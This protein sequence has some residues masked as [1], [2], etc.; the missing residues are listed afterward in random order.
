MVDGTSPHVLEPKFPGLIDEILDFAKYL[1]IE[2]L[3]EYASEIKKL[4]KK[5]VDFIKVD[6]VI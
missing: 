3:E 4:I 5:K 6:I 1:N 2:L